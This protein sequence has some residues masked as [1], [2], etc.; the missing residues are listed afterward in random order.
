MSPF[1]FASPMR[2]DGG[3]SRTKAL[4]ECRTTAIGSPSS[5]SVVRSASEG[6]ALLRYE[7]LVSDSSDVS[8]QRRARGMRQTAMMQGTRDRE[9]PQADLLFDRLGSNCPRSFTNPSFL[10][11]PRHRPALLHCRLKR[12]ALRPPTLQP[13]RYENCRTSFNTD[14]E[15]HRYSPRLK[16]FTSLHSRQA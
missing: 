6:V 15:R 12:H 10:P 2:R 13:L 11:H 14:H 1:R 4:S 3:G 9:L 5:K 8:L 16:P 7:I